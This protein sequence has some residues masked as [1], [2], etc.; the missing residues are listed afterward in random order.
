M[1]KYTKKQL[2]EILRWKLKIN[3]FKA[4]QDFSELKAELRWENNQNLREFKKNSNTRKN[5][6]SN[7][8]IFKHY[9]KTNKTIDSSSWNY[10]RER[11]LY[12]IMP[13]GWDIIAKKGGNI[14]DAGCGDGDTIQ[15]LIDYILRTWKK[16]NIKPK[17]INIFGCDISNSRLENARRFVK[18]KSKYI[19]VKFI[20]LDLS[21]KNIT[22]FKKNF[23]DYCICTGF[24]DMLN[25]ISFE[26]FM[27]NISKIV[28]RGIYIQDL[29]EHFPGGFPRENLGMEL[30]KR[31]FK[32]KEKYK[33]FNQPFNKKKLL[34]PVISAILLVQNLYA[35]KN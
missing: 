35:E 28:K 17:N 21:K 31:G 4:T 23:F 5:M 19:K 27:T 8:K 33:I 18:T 16:N 9:K 10:L 15:N 7:K 30:F 13:L 6:L 32:I 3:P 1:I 14:I 25:P 22:L 26:N 12:Y 34:E 29:L 2:N 20:N 24:L 11:K